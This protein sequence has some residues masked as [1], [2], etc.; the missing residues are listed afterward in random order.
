[1]H[2]VPRTRRSGFT[3][4]ELLLT[5]VLVLGLLGAVVFNFTTF[6]KGAAL[7]EGAVQMEALFRFARAHAASTGRQ[8]RVEFRPQAAATK[9]ES[10]PTASEP[11]KEAGP[12]VRVVW[13]PD[14]IEA[15]GVFE[16]LA[17]ASNYVEGI[18]E[19]VNVQRVVLGDSPK[20][21]SASLVAAGSATTSADPMDASVASSGVA[22]AR[23]PMQPV[24]FYPDGSGDNVQVVLASRSED[25]ERRLAVRMVG[26]TGSIQ[27]WVM[28][29]PSVAETRPPASAT[30]TEAAAE[31]EK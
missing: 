26:V 29:D 31:V 18:R 16:E 27:K 11:Q 6:Q 21:T 14:P 13:E 12:S 24:M 1:M 20:A 15:P 23:D 19:A 7:D 10:V 25:D 2:P 22:P 30:A 4:V 3:L 5:V 17:E 28:P 8:V 9:D